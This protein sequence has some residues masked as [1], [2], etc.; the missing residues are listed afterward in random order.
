MF[1]VFASFS[2][3]YRIS[4]MRSMF[5]QTKLSR[6]EP[7]IESPSATA[8]LE[9]DIFFSV[10][11]LFSSKA[12]TEQ[13]QPQN[14]MPVHN[15]CIKL[16]RPQSHRAHINHQYLYLCVYCMCIMRYTSQMD[17]YIPFITILGIIITSILT[18]V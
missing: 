18:I 12:A 9:Y 5:A 17:V 13:Q 1:L 10:V 15:T 2:G 8:H 16:A 6:T 3:R 7:K 11:F 14:Q 4:N